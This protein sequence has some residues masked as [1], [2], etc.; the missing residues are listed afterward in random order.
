M[1]KKIFVTW[2]LVLASS[3][4]LVHSFHTRNFLSP[5]TSSEFILCLMLFVVP[6]ISVQIKLPIHEVYVSSRK[7]FTFTGY[8]CT[9]FPIGMLLGANRTLNLFLPVIALSYGLMGLAWVFLVQDNSFKSARRKI[10]W[11]LWKKYPDLIGGAGEGPNQ[12]ISLLL[13]REPTYQEHIPSDFRGYFVTTQ[14]TNSV[15]AA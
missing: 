14:I 5:M 3:L 4:L 13:K 12:T 11:E 15:I 7:L 2:F 1:K 9:A 8:L 6:M 10:C